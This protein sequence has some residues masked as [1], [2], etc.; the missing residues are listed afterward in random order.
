MDPSTPNNLCGCHVNMM[1]PR[2]NE[3]LLMLLDN[4]VTQ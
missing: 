2:E 4:V 3:G 1:L